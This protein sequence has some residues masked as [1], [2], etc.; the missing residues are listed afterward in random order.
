MSKMFKAW[1]VS[2]LSI[3]WK[4]RGLEIME[5]MCKEMRVNLIR[6][7]IGNSPPI[8]QELEAPEITIVLY[9]RKLK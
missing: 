1:L 8:G 5:S 9:Q 7:Q 2:L 3:G 4:R 6:S